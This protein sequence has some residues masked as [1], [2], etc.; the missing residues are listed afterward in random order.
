MRRGGE[1]FRRRLF[2]PTESAGASLQ[3]LAGIFAAK[4]AAFK[5]LELPAGNWHVVQIA[6]RPDG[7]AVPLLRAR[8]R[9]VPDRQ[10]GPQHHALRRIRVRLR[11]CADTGRRIEERADGADDRSF[12][13]GCRAPIRRPCGAVVQAGVPL[14][15]LELSGS[16][17]GRRPR[18]RVAAA[19]RRRQGRPR[20]QSGG[21]TPR[22]GC[23]RTSA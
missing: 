21:R 14:P 10:P 7:P 12:P 20:D 9:C 5:A 8:V 2:H 11:R 13:A 1:P 3:R 4:E 22:T 15:P 18:R 23:W 6:H 16:L 17:G 19:A